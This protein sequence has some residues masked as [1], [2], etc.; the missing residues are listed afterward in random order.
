VQLLHRRKLQ[1]QWFQ[2]TLRQHRHSIFGT[3][4]IANDDLSPCQVDALNA[5]F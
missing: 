2:H 5:W 1:P 4:A 3:L